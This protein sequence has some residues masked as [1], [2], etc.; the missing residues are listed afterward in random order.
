MTLLTKRQ[1][2]A[3]R[4]LFITG[5]RDLPRILNYLATRGWTIREGSI[6][7]ICLISYMVK[8]R[9]K[10]SMQEVKRMQR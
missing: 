6:E 8:L 4:S 3:I 9:R 7:Y 5:I 10:K 1:K 2:F